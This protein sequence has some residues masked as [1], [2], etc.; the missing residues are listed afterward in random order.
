M[1]DFG[2]TSHRDQ[3][4]FGGDLGAQKVGN[5][6]PLNYQPLKANNYHVNKNKL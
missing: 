1:D 5:L 4:I 2:N 3:I 6:L